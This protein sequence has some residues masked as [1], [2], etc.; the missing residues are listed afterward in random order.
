MH[1]FV[2]VAVDQEQEFGQG[3]KV[4]IPQRQL[5]ELA[6]ND[7]CKGTKIPQRGAH[8]GREKETV[9]KRTEA[10]EKLLWGR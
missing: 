4:N 2:L 3:K 6:L 1:P 5:F 9:R 8:R 10:V 7:T